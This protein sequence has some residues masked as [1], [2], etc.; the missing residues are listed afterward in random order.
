[1]WS[2]ARYEPGS[3]L[4]SHVDIPQL[5]PYVLDGSFGS[6]TEMVLEPRPLPGSNVF[7]KRQKVLLQRRSLLLIF[8]EARDKWK[9]QIP[10][11][12]YDTVEKRRIHETPGC[13]FFSVT[14]VQEQT[15][16]R[17]RHSPLTPDN[18]N[19]INDPALGATPPCTRDMIR[20]S[21]LLV[22]QVTIFICSQAW[23]R[24]RSATLLVRSMNSLTPVKDRYA[25][26]R[27]VGFHC[28]SNH[29]ILPSRGTLMS[30]QNAAGPH[31]LA[32]SLPPISATTVEVT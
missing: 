14:L 15:S 20:I 26:I 28:V 24:H 16:L 27:L 5:G 13:H 1:M 22:L 31:I 11:R 6:G 21:R 19:R 25:L 18:V 23:H 17:H 30:L 12:D 3:G 10:A 2:V 7:K 4:R 9:H 32:A 8:G 29:F